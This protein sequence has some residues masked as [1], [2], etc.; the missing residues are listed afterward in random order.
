[1]GKE[2]RIPKEEFPLRQPQGGQ[3]K[4]VTRA[5]DVQ[6]QHLQRDRDGKVREE[7]ERLLS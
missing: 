1:M 2:R 3:D 5:C 6:G 4:L 7:R